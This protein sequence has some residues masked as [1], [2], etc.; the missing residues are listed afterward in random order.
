MFMEILQIKRVC[1]I[2][3]QANLSAKTLERE[4]KIPPPEVFPETV[5]FCHQTA[6]K[7]QTSKR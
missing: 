6:R 4:K 2:R 5:F 7:T 3:A 1:D